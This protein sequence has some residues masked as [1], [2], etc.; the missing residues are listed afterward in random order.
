M[1]SGGMS[2][3]KYLL[4]A[5]N[6]VFVVSVYSIYKLIA[7]IKEIIESIDRYSESYCY[8]PDSRLSLKSVIMSS[9]WRRRPITR[10][11]LWLLSGSVSLCWRFSGVVVPSKRALV[12]SQRYTTYDNTFDTFP[13][14]LILCRI[15]VQF[16]NISHSSDRIDWRRTYL[17]L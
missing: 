4:F 17:C 3:V 15:A 1:V 10:P 16:N 5:F 6:L 9:F 7:F 14:F 11:S 12:C 13:I 8:T 2:C